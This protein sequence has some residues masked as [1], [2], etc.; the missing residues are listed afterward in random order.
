MGGFI[1]EPD[2]LRG[3]AEPGG[4]ETE[5]HCLADRVTSAK[6]PCKVTITS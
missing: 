6:A 1:R 5:G 2:F 3:K 4:D